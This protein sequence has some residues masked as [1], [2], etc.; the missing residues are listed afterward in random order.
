M[1]YS[2]GLFSCYRTV[3]YIKNCLECNRYLFFHLHYT[4]RWAP[5]R[6]M[7]H[8]GI[9]QLTGLYGL[10]IVIQCKQCCLLLLT[11]GARRRARAGCWPLDVAYQRGWAAGL[12]LQRQQQR[13]ANTMNEFTRDLLQFC[14]L[15]MCLPKL[16]GL[17]PA[18]AQYFLV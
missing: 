8:N 13:I 12:P 6:S 14:L 11:V 7:V 10:A 16:T 18:A 3:N 2:C 5:A 1:I 15:C 9:H 4:L 17:S